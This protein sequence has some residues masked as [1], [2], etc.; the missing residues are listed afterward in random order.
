MKVVILCGGKGQRMG[1]AAEELPK[2]MLPINN[3]PIIIH[4]MN[5]YIKYGFN[6]F[7]LP[8]GY[9]GSRIKQYFKD[10]EWINCDFKKTIG[11]EQLEIL[12]KQNEFHVTLVDTGI[13]T[14][15]GSRIKQL[16]RFIDD[17]FMVTY[18]DGISDINIK[19]L[20]EFH[21]KSGK[22]ATVTGI[23]QKSQYGILTV[24]DELVTAFTE[25]QSVDG[26]INGGFFVFNK[27]I[28]NY[29]SD[30]RSCILEGTPLQSLVTDQ[31]LS[32]YMHKG[33][34]KSIDTQK[35][36]EEANEKWRK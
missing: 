23:V 2:P 31:Q 35:D 16:E 29:L 3:K 19:K 15:T 8:L 6:D 5:Q 32:V 33:F 30:D 20:L 26:I 12:Q 28:F 25:K 27:E 18:G 34:W 22:I 4:I 1:T 11:Q 36:L 10:Y 24:K 17:T 21:K 7:L 13:S 14:M 9:K